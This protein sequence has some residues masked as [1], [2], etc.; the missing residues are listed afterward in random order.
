[1]NDKVNTFPGRRP[2]CYRIHGQTVA[3]WGPSIWWKVNSVIRWKDYLV[4]DDSYGPPANRV[5]LASSYIGCPR[6]IRQAYQDAMT[7]V[8][9]C[10]KPTFFL[11]IACNPQWE[12]I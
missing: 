3:D 4:G 10:K 6:A 5:I 1:M 2:Y 8:D 9:L 11:I 12:E 7:I